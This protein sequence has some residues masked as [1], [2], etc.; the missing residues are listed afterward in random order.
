MP[1]RTTVVYCMEW[2]EGIDCWIII[3]EGKKGLVR[4]QSEWVV[5]VDIGCVELILGIGSSNL[6]IAMESLPFT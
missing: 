4:Y 6:A 2:S 3:V 5:G 1:G